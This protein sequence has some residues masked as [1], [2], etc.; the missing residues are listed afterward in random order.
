MEKYM[1]R[2]L[3]ILSCMN[4][5]GAETFLMKIYR[6][7]DRTKYQ[8]DFCVNI[9]EEGFYDKEITEMGGRIFHIPAKS[10]NLKEF[11]RQLTSIIKDE[12]YESV[13]RITSN[14]MG[15]LDLKVAKKA[16]AK[17][18]AARS[19]N[20]NDPAGIKAKIAHR[21]GR[22]LYG[23]YVDV[24]IAPSDLAAIYTFGDRAYKNGEVKILHN[25]LDLNIYKYDSE[26]R[27]KI[28]EE[29]GIGEK[30]VIGHV[31]RF[32]KQKNHQ[33]LIRV[34]KEVKKR[35]HKAVLLLVGE[36]PE[37][38]NIMSQVK[39]MGLSNSVIFAGIRKDIPAI[40]SAMDVFAFPSLYEGMPNTVI[41]AQ[42]CGLDC[43]VSDSI[44]RTV[45]ITGKVLFK[46]IKYINEWVPLLSEKTNFTKDET[47]QL[48]RDACY[49]I[50]D[51]TKTFVEYIF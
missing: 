30:Y 11:K 44:T 23:K 37:K 34:F 1:K 45:N 16:G 5:G 14:T 36:G 20:S 4:A 2:V 35:N 12:H 3:C 18:C 42:A 15:F 39:S 25:A 29:F 17:V 8:M 49:D 22:I 10:D 41:E 51:V 21:L 47:E 48:I 46:S 27:N 32:E 33:F 7:I 26:G 31:G 28:R 24:K 9:F 13:L 6:N 19:S 40:L 50:R 38:Q 43:V